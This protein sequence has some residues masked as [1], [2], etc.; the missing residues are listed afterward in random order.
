MEGKS[1]WEIALEQIKSP[2]ERASE[3][4]TAGHFQTQEMI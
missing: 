1:E 4:R 3:Y 2:T